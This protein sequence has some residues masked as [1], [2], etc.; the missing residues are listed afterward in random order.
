M[1]AGS[2][3]QEDESAIEEE[4]EKLQSEDLVAELPDVPQKVI[5]N[6]QRKEEQDAQKVK[7]TKQPVVVLT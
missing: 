7:D 6:P 2:L 4:F 3:T 5:Q 1:L